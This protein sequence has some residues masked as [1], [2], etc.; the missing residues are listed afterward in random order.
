MVIIVFWILFPGCQDEQT[1]IKYLNIKNAVDTIIVG[2][3]QTSDR[4]VVRRCVTE[5][6]RL[7]L[8]LWRPGKG[9]KAS[10]SVVFTGESGLVLELRFFVPY[11]KGQVAHIEVRAPEAEPVLVQ[12]CSMPTIGRL[13]SYKEFVF[14]RQQLKDWSTSWKWDEI[15]KNSLSRRM[16]LLNTLVT[17]E[18][19][20]PADEGRLK[21]LVA[22]LDKLSIDRLDD[23]RDF[24]EVDVGQLLD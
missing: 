5:A 6:N 8:K 19:A 23:F 15:D 22:Q 4:D 7:P 24:L 17:K 12:F 14:R 16:R 1:E 3:V 2:S 10:R 13:I 21:E 20:V 18:I 11:R 9:E